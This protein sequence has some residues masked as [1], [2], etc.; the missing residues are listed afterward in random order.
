MLI[1]CSYPGLTFVREHYDLPSLTL[2]VRCPPPT[3]PRNVLD[4]GQTVQ[5]ARACGILT[6]VTCDLPDM[7]EVE[8]LRNR[9]R[10]PIV[11]KPLSKADD[12][13]T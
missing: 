10:F 1:P 13:Q 12:R 8:R 11:A 5:A 9:L 6:P 3:V 2:H 7:A 4:K